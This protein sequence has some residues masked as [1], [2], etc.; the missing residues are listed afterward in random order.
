L[1]KLSDK[2]EKFCQEYLLD[3]NASQAAKR[4][5]YSKKTAPFIG[6][7][8]L[9]KPQIKKRIAEL[10]VKLQK[11]VGVTPE[12]ITEG[13]KKI[14]FGKKSKTLK[15]KDRIS[16]M[17]NLGKHIGYYEKDNSQ[18][19]MTLADFLKAMKKND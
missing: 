15:N 17:E 8:N 3:L 5:G 10:K 6:A 14:A 9:K 1:S 2:M 18:Q 11:K 7:E 13:F 16:A 4:A 12:M 19:G